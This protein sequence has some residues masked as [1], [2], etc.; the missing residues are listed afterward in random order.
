MSGSP[1]PSAPFRLQARPG[2]AR[3][4]T[5]YAVMGALP[6]YAVL[7]ALM[8]GLPGA[9][10]AQGGREPDRD[11]ARRNEAVRREDRELVALMDAAMEGRA[12][13]DFAMAWRNDFF[14]AQAGTFVPFTVT[15]DR[16][17]LSGAS[18]AMY[19]RAARRG[20]ARAGETRYPFDLVFPVDLGEPGS[21]PLRITRG[22]AVP[23]GDYD[24]YVALRERPADP[25]ARGPRPKAGVLKQ[26]VSVPDFW[27]GDLAASSVMLA[28]RI[29]AVDP[30]MP[31]DVLERPYVIGDRE[32]HPAGEA[33]F[34][35]DRELIVV[36]LIY[37]PTVSADGAYDIQVD[38]DLFRADA[39][40][41]EPP[42]RVAGGPQG[43]PGER[44]VTRT[45]P[46]RFRPSLMAPSF[47]PASGQPMLAGQGILLSSIEAGA[48]RLG[49]TVTDLLSHRT[50][51]RD[52][53]FRVVGS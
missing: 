35:R 11:Q 52:V 42:G 9:A 38:Y 1:D 5:A 25:E 45:E 26:P 32:V 19:V 23:A 39:G 20:T 13:S 37:N 8:L 17:G 16:A 28:D 27:S 3:P 4:Q 36:F 44:Y 31:E 18:A 15:V 48:Y 47:D 22:F 2:G 21:G 40:E 51:S 41:D 34:R 7:A 43:R 30:V 53:T 49:I 29:D 50:L 12:A 10:T 33:I 24:V 14:K 46:Q 6:A